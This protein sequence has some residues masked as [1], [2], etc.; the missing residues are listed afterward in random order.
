MPWL[1]DAKI[2]ELPAEQRAELARTTIVGTVHCLLASGMLSGLPFLE[3][4]AL[5]WDGWASA[6]LPVPHFVAALRADPCGLAWSI[7]WLLRLLHVGTINLCMSVFGYHFM[8]GFFS[9]SRHHS[10]KGFWA[11]YAACRMFAQLMLLAAV[12]VARLGVG[13]AGGARG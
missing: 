12:Q 2:K 9:S 11:E 4:I 6:A 7:T 5:A 3:L 13:L 10:F 1:R 8:I